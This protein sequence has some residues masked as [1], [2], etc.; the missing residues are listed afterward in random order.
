MAMLDIEGATL[1]FL[2]VPVELLQPAQQRAPCSACAYLAPADLCRVMRARAVA[3]GL[4]DC[5][6]GF[7]YREVVW[8]ER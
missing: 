8:D 4:P 6:S 3:W 2:A 7:V 1:R 5:S